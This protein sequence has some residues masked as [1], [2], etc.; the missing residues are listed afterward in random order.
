MA[1]YFHTKKA[2]MLLD[3][4]NTRIDQHEAKGKITTWRRLKLD[5]YTHVAQQWAGKAFFRATV[6][7]E[8]LRFNIIKPENASIPADVY[9]Y[10]HGHLI[11]TFINHF[12]HDFESATA[13]PSPRIGD[14]VA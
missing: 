14:R 5:Y 7:D 1:V 10:Y 6:D 12:A 3:A 4:F 2:Q 8:L 11:E 9:A 13:T